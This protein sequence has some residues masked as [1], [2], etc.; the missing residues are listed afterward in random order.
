MFA[1]M[2]LFLPFVGMSTALTEFHS[3]QVPFG[4]SRT[5]LCKTDPTWRCNNITEE[6]INI[7]H[8]CLIQ[9]TSCKHKN[10]NT[11]ISACM[12]RCLLIGDIHFSLT[13]CGNPDKS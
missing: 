13:A 3:I 1:W 7:G 10:A 4:D 2:P 9:P 8:R 11:G 12:A 5:L 6:V